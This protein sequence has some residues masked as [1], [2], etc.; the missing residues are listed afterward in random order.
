M[1]SSD[2]VELAELDKI[3]ASLKKELYDTIVKSRV[4][5]KNIREAI[6]KIVTAELEEYKKIEREAATKVDEIV[7]LART[8]PIIP[9]NSSYYEEYKNQF[10][11]S[12]RERIKKLR[13]EIKQNIKNN[14]LIYRD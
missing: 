2:V 9:E 8:N 3:I 12:E 13:E 5:D 1:E 10:I 14:T 11:V 4:I 6:V 7:R